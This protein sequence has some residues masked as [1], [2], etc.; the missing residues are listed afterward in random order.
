MHAQ[1]RRG[2]YRAVFNRRDV[3]G[4]FRPEPLPDAVLSRILHAAHQAPSVGFMQPWDFI[5]IRLRAVRERIHRDFCT[6]HGEAA[7]M[8]EAAR[9]ETYRGLKLEGILEAPLNLCIT[10]DRE[11]SGGPVIGRTP[12]QEMD[13]Y[14]TVCA[15]QN[16]W[17][18]ARVE[19]GGVGWVSI[20]HRE[21]LSEILALPATVVPVAYLC[22]GYVSHFPERPELETAGWHSRTPL[23]ELV[24]FERWGQGAT[25]A[26]EPLIAQLREDRDF[27]ATF[28]A[29]ESTPGEH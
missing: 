26:E 11:R 8:F 4:Q 7:E 27:P 14:S 28:N 20:L 22:L 5:L 3:R 6:A 24:A 25:A 29:G 16:L 1:E 2:L 10:R 9:R 21:V 15:V 19:G 18:A 13:L 17:L 12:Q 23:E